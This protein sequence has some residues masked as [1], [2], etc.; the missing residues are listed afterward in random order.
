MIGAFGLLFSVVDEIVFITRSSLNDVF[1]A[2]ITVA[3]SATVTINS[4]EWL[5]IIIWNEKKREIKKKNMHDY[6]GRPQPNNTNIWTIIFMFIVSVEHESL[7][8]WPYIASFRQKKDY[9]S[10]TMDK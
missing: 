2:Q 1:S 9:V 6:I 7:L 5:D 8:K 3:P 10:S 4:H